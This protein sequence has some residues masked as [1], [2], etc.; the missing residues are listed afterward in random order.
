MNAKTYCAQT[1]KFLG[2]V[3]QA[4]P[5]M[6]SDIMQGWIENPKSLKKILSEALCPPPMDGI[7]GK[8]TAVCV[9]EKGE[10]WLDRKEYLTRARE[11][12]GGRSDQRAFDFYSKREN[13]HLLPDDV[14]VIIFPDT[15]FDSD[16][17]RSVRVLCRLGV[18]WLRNYD[19]VSDGFYP[20]SHVAVLA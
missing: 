5:E 2:C 13:Q 10:E 12:S 14:E 16:G 8:L 11:K 18:R 7:F 6:P 4:M 15:E 17:S 20:R 1:A 9:H 3:A 19:W